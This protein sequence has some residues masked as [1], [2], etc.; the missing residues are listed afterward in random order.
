ML[1]IFFYTYVAIGLGLLLP[2]IRLTNFLNFGARFTAGYG[3]LTIYIYLAHVLARLSLDLTILLAFF[4]ATIGIG[5]AIYREKHK[6]LPVLLIHPA[7]GP[8]SGTTAIT[9]RKK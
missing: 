4:L 3:L 2:K 7:F 1:G 5:Y 6:Y 9:L 8:S